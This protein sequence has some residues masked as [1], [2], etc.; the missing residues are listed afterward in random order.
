MFPTQIY[1]RK[2]RHHSTPPPRYYITSIP[3]RRKDQICIEPPVQSYRNTGVTSL[4]LS[5]TSVCWKLLEEAD[6]GEEEE[7]HGAG[8]IWGTLLIK[9]QQTNKPDVVLIPHEGFHLSILSH[10]TR[11]KLK[12]S[13]S[14]RHKII[15]TI[16]QR[17]WSVHHE[18]PQKCTSIFTLE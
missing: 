11:L 12:S 8:C 5:E 13:Y 10:R 14:T 2:T 9:P 6:G 17:Q 15:V 18:L 7:G 3:N 4:S 16:K 1:M